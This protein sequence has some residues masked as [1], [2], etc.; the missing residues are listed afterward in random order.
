[1]FIPPC[2]PKD[3]KLL[4]V[5][6][7]GGYTAAIRLAELGKKV[8]VVDEESV[9]GVC[10]HHGCIPSKAFIHAAHLY[11][12]ANQAKEMGILVGDL[13]FDFSK[14]LA[15]KNKVVENLDS[16]IRALFKHHH[17][18]LIKAKAFF[19][20][21]N[22]IALRPVNGD[23]DINALEF[24]NCIIACGSRERDLPG[25]PV[26]GKN[27]ITSQH[28]LQMSK[29]PKSM[30]IIGGGYIGIELS[31]VFA[32][33]GVSI[34]IVEALPSILNLLD[35]DIS[36][37][38]QKNLDLLK[39]KTFCGSKVEKV[40]VEGDQ[41]KT[42]VALDGK[43]ETFSTEKVLVA[44]GR[45]SHADGLSLQNTKVKLDKRGFVQVS[46]GMQTHD[47]RIFAIGDIVGGVMLAHKASFEGKIAAEVIAG[48][49]AGFD[50]VV[51]YAIFSD[52]EIAGVGLNEKEAQKKGISYKMERFKMGGLGKAHIM[53]TTEGFFKI[54]YD[55][56]RIL[57]CH[58]IG[59]RAS[60]MIGEAVLAMEMGATIEDLSLIIHPHPTLVEGFGELA[61]KA[62]GLPINSL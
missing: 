24:K 3:P 62:L 16:G 26:D 45:V 13:T 37:V 30:L 22:K 28:A 18:S 7:P 33:L 36:K 9:G 54:L 35:D 20:A 17:I 8:T 29:L 4:M 41:V 1:M 60:D 19:E 27:I 52:P 53:G 51:P 55:S 31:Q 21:S 25:I 10:L 39:V 47:P 61:D 49:K 43:K 2:A 32:K 5:K 42:T 15:W 40:V 58:I 11:H 48:K 34:M 46:D 57:G 14:T 50:N 6:D 59:E 38:V 23:I 56:S 12:Q 44:V